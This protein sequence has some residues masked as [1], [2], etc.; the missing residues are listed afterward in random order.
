MTDD[1]PVQELRRAFD[2]GAWEQAERLVGGKSEHH[3]VATDRGR[4]VLRRSYRAKEADG[5]RFEHQLVA[6]LRAQ[7]FPAPEFVPT[8]TGDACAEIDGRLWRASVFV[9][10]EPAD[11]RN[12]RHV[13]AVAGAL[14]RYHELVESFAPSVPPPPVPLVGDALRQRHDAVAALEAAGAPGGTPPELLVALA[15]ALA[16][17]RA[18]ADRLDRLYAG[19]ALTTVHAGC[20]RGSTLFEGDR[21][22]CVLDFDSAH[23][24]VRALDVAVAVFDFAKVYGDPDSSEY[25]V[26]VDTSVAA[27]FLSSYSAAAARALGP[28]E[29]EA[30]RLLIVAKRLKR[31]LGRYRRLFHAEP[32]SPNDLRKIALELDRVRSL[33]SRW[34]DLVVT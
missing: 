20:R 11:G 9:P 14:A 7:G 19:L 27:R 25:K 32:L 30:V 12:P 28:D 34:G 3:L 8:M 15:A 10:G 6:H 21:L 26:H 17:A 16:D 24:D 29:I 13:D 4:F 33:R 1:L 5:I 31:A 18:T 22:A 23:A 2:L